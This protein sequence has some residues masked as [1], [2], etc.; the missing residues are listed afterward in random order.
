MSKEIL[1]NLST[2]DTLIF[3]PILKYEHK[4]VYVEYKDNTV[5][6]WDE[7]TSDGKKIL[8]SIGLD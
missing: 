7:K 1:V 8:I 3:D 2:P 6:V 5:G 4:F